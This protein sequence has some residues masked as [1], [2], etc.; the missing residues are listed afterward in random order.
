MTLPLLKYARNNKN[1][2]YNIHI[3][4]KKIFSLLIYYEKRK[5][6]RL[7]LLNSEKELR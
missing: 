2:H 5:C 7:T 1:V 4:K 6:T 3:R